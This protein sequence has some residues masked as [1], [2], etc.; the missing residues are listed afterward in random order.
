MELAAGNTRS[1]LRK[2]VRPSE[3]STIATPIT[4]SDR[5]AISATRFSS[6]FQSKSAGASVVAGCALGWPKVL[7]TVTKAMTNA[8]SFARRG[9]AA[10]THGRINL[11]KQAQSRLPFTQTLRPGDSDQPPFGCAIGSACPVAGSLHSEQPGAAV[12]A[13]NPAG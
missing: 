10:R 4:P 7:P 13:G 11:T 5:S 6:F 12:C 3:R 2:I 9:M 1:A 8:T